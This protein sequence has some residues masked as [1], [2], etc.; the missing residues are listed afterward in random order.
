[1]KVSDDESSMGVCRNK[2]EYFD[3]VC[4][5]WIGLTFSDGNA[6]LSPRCQHKTAE[7]ECG[8]VCKFLY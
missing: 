7:K 2:E 8:V 3:T 5:L 6:A 1:M 4:R